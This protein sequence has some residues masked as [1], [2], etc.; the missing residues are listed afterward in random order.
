[1][2]G[3]GNETKIERDSK[4]TRQRDKSEAEGRETKH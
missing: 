3:R 2:T 1:M 4:E